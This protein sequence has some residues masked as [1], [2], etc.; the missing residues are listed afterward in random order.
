MRNEALLKKVTEAAKAYYA[1]AN[2]NTNSFG[3]VVKEPRKLKRALK[4]AEDDAFYNGFD[5][6]EI[7]L[8]K[9]SGLTMAI[10]GEK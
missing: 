10:K 8:A 7:E 9:R 6:Y 5:E 3:I 1:E 4:K 2:K